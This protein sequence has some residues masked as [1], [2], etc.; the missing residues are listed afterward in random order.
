ML[1]Q[2]RPHLA[3]Q[4][5]RR[6]RCC[7]RSLNAACRGD[8]APA[9]TR[10]LPIVPNA[11]QSSIGRICVGRTTCARSSPQTRWR[12]RQVWLCC[13]PRGSCLH[14]QVPPSRLSAR[15]RAHLHTESPVSRSIRQAG[16][17]EGLLAVAFGTCC[18][19]PYPPAR[20]PRSIVHGRLRA[21]KSAHALVRSRRTLTRS[22]ARA[23][24]RQTASCPAKAA[25]CLLEARKPCDRSS[26]LRPAVAAAAA[27]AALA[28]EPC[29]MR[30]K[31]H[32]LL[33]ATVGTQPS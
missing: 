22:A 27:A 9:S 28:A 6:S 24:P 20:A 11:L 15:P 2:A 17:G 25:H 21:I 19:P 10:H 16:A 33:P 12:H 1:Q 3:C 29:G 4:A 13:C 31:L 14:A 5:C 8:E 18:H 32:L 23:E 26:R 30:S 7:G